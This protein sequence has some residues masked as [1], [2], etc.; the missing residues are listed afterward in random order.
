[1]VVPGWLAKARGSTE[2]MSFQ[3]KKFLGFIDVL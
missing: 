1:M 3:G 2:N